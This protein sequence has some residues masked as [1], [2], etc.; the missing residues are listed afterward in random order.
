MCGP[1]RSCEDV[2][3][4]CKSRTRIGIDSKIGLTITLQILGEDLVVEELWKLNACSNKLYIHL[5]DSTL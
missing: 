1:L 2:A 4:E 3:E 5:F